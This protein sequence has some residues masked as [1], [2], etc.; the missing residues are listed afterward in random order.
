MI[1]DRSRDVKYISVIVTDYSTADQWETQRYYWFLSYY[2]LQQYSVKLACL[3]KNYRMHSPRDYYIYRF[4]FSGQNVPNGPIRLS[5]NGTLSLSFTSGRVQLLYNSTW[6]NICVD[7]NF[8]MTEATVICHQLGYTSARSYSRAIN[9]TYAC[10][11]H[12]FELGF[13]FCHTDLGWTK[14]PHCSTMLTVQQICI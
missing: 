2:R 7:Y 14:A 1:Y 6:G 12:T 3:S 9:D 5:Q 4:I 10:I 13:D 11:M 8:G